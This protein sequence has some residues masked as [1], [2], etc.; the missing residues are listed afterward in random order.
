LHH[1]RKSSFA[2]LR[3]DPLGHDPN[4]ILSG[5]TGS[6]DE[7]LD[8]KEEEIVGSQGQNGPGGVSGICGGEAAVGIIDE[9]HQPHPQ[10]HL[11]R[12][13]RSLPRFEKEMCGKLVQTRKLSIV[14]LSTE[15][16]GGV[17]RIKRFCSN[18]VFAKRAIE[19]HWKEIVDQ[20]RDMYN[21]GIMH[22]MVGYGL[23]ALD[24]II[25]CYDST[26]YNREARISRRTTFPGGDDVFDM[27]GKRGGEGRPRRIQVR[28]RSHEL[29]I[30]IH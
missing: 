24:V 17:I 1:R 28:V 14:G 19:R 3:E 26:N 15:M 25:D 29:K 23:L 16:E 30:E 13:T 2:A 9:D 4:A 22:D 21:V 27:V 12:R 18:C 8:R 6:L 5:R 7:R 20:G 11:L 10:S